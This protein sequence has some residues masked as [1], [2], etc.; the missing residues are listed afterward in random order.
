LLWP[1]GP[2]GAVTELPGD[3]DRIATKHEPRGVEQDFVLGG[4][5]LGLDDLNG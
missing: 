2:L 1:N 3:L 4:A 5:D